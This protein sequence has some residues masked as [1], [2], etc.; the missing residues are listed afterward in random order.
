MLASPSRN[1]RRRQTLHHPSVS[2]AQFQS[3]PHHRSLAGIFLLALL[4]L[5]L[6][7]GFLK[8]SPW[9]PVLLGPTLS[10]LVYLSIS[11]TCI[12]A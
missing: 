5:Q 4:V 11:S 6:G 12:Y 9:T 10:Q 2:S 3:A 1:W 8:A 7:P